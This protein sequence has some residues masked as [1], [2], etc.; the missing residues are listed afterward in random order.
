MAKAL[1]KFIIS[2][3]QP[4]LT[5]VGWVKPIKGTNRCNLLFYNNGEWISE[6]ETSLEF[7]DLESKMSE[8]ESNDAKQDRTINGLRDQVENYKPIVINGNVT[9]AADEEDLTSENGLI[10]I[11]NR[12]SLD[13]MGYVILRKDKTFA[14]Q[15]TLAN[16]IYEIR[17]DFELNENSIEI[18]VDCTLVFNGGSISNGTIIGNNTQFE[19][20]KDSSILC[21]FGGTFADCTINVNH[22]GLIAKGE[23]VNIQSDFERLEHL[24]SGTK[25]I[26]VVFP[27]GVYCYG[28]GSKIKKYSS[29]N[30]GYYNY[31]ALDIKGDV[32]INLRI[33]GNGAK[34]IRKCE[35]YI[36]KWD[37]SVSPFQPNF[38]DTKDYS[39]YSTGAG[40]LINE[41]STCQLFEMRNCVHEF[42]LMG[43]K[44]GGKQSVT[45]EC[46]CLLFRSNPKSIIV[47]NCEFNNFITD[48][49]T[50]G[51][52]LFFSVNNCKFY[53]NI[54]WAISTANANKIN[55]NGCY[56][57][58]NGH[59]FSP[60]EYY[61]FEGNN[62]DID[63][64]APANTQ[65]GDITVSNCTI[66][67]TG[68]VNS[69]VGKNNNIKSITYIN[70]TCYNSMTAKLGTSSNYTGLINVGLVNDF[71]RIENNRIT[72]YRFFV[73]IIGTA[74]LATDIPQETSEDVWWYNGEQ[75]NVPLIANNVMSF[76]E[77]CVG[78][79]NNIIVETSRAEALYT[80]ECK[81]FKFNF[82]TQKW[83]ID[84]SG[85]IAP[86]YFMGAL[87]RNNVINIIDW[88]CI[89]PNDA[90][91]KGRYNRLI[92]DNL[93]INIYKKEDNW[94]IFKNIKPTMNPNGIVFRNLIINDYG[95]LTKE[96]TTYESL[97]RSNGDTPIQYYR[98]GTSAFNS[99][100]FG[101]T[102]SGYMPVEYVNS[103]NTMG[104]FDQ[105]PTLT[106][107]NIG[108]E[109]YDTTNK[110]K[111][112]WNGTEWT[113]L[114]GSAL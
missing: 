45:A 40:F 62:G 53:R 9:N 103:Y 4:K 46:S 19:G 29:G 89:G 54:R 111:I 67:D 95:N 21:D 72:N 10:K 87:F 42:D 36:G 84:T 68:G 51:D 48:G 52:P 58:K 59:Y 65:I 50:C 34:F 35:T 17:Y 56:F 92:F 104:T 3:S 7:E 66:K 13:G 113:N 69:F 98:F 85:T 55:I 18:P 91:N 41:C 76:T 23:N 43:A 12:S 74:P 105:K 60:N 70:N 49:I 102:E 108:F 112:M 30:R 47:E 73:P 82:S 75:I 11:N 39:K 63:C 15:V 31:F 93:V 86:H 64:E 107:N 2:E 114:D 106:I 90:S 24:I 109:Y 1:N 27:Y 94:K 79:G 32:N 44:Y 20:L 99:V 16:T 100:K 101:P 33:E 8:L 22:I 110:R 28:R 81:N 25:T 57:E 61:T 83:D 80:S 14:E 88:V 78:W 37:F 26:N 6:G 71:V 5:N 38:D 97:M 96:P 77:D